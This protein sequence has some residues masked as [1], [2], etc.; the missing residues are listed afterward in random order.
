M[1]SK[2]KTKSLHRHL[3]YSYR[4]RRLRGHRQYRTSTTL[5]TTIGTHIF[6]RLF[7]RTFVISCT[8]YSTVV[9][10]VCS[11]VLERVYCT[12]IVTNK[13]LIT[14]IRN[15]LLKKWR[16]LRNHR[17]ENTFAPDAL[18]IIGSLSTV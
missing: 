10:V 8:V 15:Y 16:K 18:R 12:Q 7:E 13:S 2:S 17:E 1:S 14:L 5:H 9:L 3:L 4:I 11:T 6:R